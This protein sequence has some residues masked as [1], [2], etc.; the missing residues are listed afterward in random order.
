MPIDNSHIH[1][2][3]RDIKAHET[4]RTYDMGSAL[5]NIIVEDKPVR[6]RMSHWYGYQKEAKYDPIAANAR[7]EYEPQNF[8]GYTKLEP[9]E[10]GEI[11]SRTPDAL[12]AR[13]I[14]DPLKQLAPILNTPAAEELV[15]SNEAG[16]SQEILRK[17]VEERRQKREQ[18]DQ[19]DAEQQGGLKQQQDGQRQQYQQTIQEHEQQHQERQTQM[20]QQRVQQGAQDGNS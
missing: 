2:T 10:V 9:A 7:T 3:L 5:N 8:V 4:D 12:K 6:D 16:N 11:I 15:G 1:G 18:Q 19:Q 20:K 17:L 13:P 14:T